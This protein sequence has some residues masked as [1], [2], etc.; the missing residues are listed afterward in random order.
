VAQ[1]VDPRFIRSDMATDAEVTAAV[2]GKL[3][4]TNLVVDRTIT[5]GG[6][7]GA[8]TINKAAG[9]VN[10]AIGSVSLVVTNSLV[11]AN[12]II[13]CTTRTDD[14]NAFV[15]SIVAAAGSFTV[16]LS[17]PPEVEVSVGFLVTN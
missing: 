6:T 16:N 1:K 12:S 2:A 8:Q 9:T 11:T 5:A 3:S 4:S 15:W 10:F 7:T 17:A 14:L 13:V